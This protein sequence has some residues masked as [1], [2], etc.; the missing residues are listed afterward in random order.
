MTNDTICRFQISTDRFKLLVS[1]ENF[2][3]KFSKERPTELKQ[4]GKGGKF[5]I[6][7]YHS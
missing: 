4:T 2:R 7:L 5:F 3:L 1:K 6:F